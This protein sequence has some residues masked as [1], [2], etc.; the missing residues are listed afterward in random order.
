MMIKSNDSKFQ[1]KQSTIKKQTQSITPRIL[2]K[3]KIDQK[4][5]K[6]KKSEIKN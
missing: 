1:K 6:E 3:A 2:S 5:L 4:L